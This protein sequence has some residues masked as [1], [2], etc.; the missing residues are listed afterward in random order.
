MA[1]SCRK[2]RQKI[3]NLKLNVKSSA[4]TVVSFKDVTEEAM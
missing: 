2:M 4:A 1:R 3:K